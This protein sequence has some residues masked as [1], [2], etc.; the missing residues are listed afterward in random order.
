MSAE[1]PMG[2]L[3]KYEYRLDVCRVSNGATIEVRV[4]TR[5]LPSDQWSTY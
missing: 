4:P 2:H 1:R 5:R 3:L